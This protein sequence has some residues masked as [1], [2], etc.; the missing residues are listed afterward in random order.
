MSL[1]VFQMGSVTKL[2]DTAVDFRIPFGVIDMMTRDRAGER[3]LQ[4]FPAPVVVEV[5]FIDF[6]KL[7][8][9]ALPKVTHPPH[10]RPRPRTG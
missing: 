10:G 3:L 1:P 2:T 9:A 4:A 6:C 7:K 8:G 5:S